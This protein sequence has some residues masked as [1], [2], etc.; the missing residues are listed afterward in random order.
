MV[1]QYS[2]GTKGDHASRRSV[3]TMRVY[4]YIW[5]LAPC[6]VYTVIRDG[7]AA[8]GARERAMRLATL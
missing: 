2:T 8:D 1:V 3:E 7:V 4:I 5:S 6:N